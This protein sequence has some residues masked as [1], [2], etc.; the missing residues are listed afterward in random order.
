MKKILKLCIVAMLVVSTVLS[1]ASCGIISGILRND[2]ETE[3]YNT[4][5]E[6]QG[7]LDE[8]A[9]DIYENWYDA[10][11]NDKFDS[12]INKAIA[13]AFKEHEADLEIIYE[14]D[15]IIVD[16]YKDIR[17][18]KLKSEAEEVMEAYNEYYTIVVECSGSFN[19]YSE[20]KEPAK[21]ALAKALKNYYIAY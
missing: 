18:G 12:D 11:Y 6:S 2:K 14:N 20:E 10:I 21:K 13:A 4:V 15:D 9:D 8:L 1:T 17:D 5:L 19:S 3:F 16:L 7:L